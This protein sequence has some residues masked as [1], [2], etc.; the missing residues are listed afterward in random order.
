M[1]H[2]K[3]FLI[4]LASSLGALAADIDVSPG[5]LESLLGDGGKGQT[6]LKLKG[7]IDARDLAALENLSADVK[8]LDL[9][10]VSIEALSMPN[11]KYFGRTLFNQGEIPAY[12]FF[13][14]NVTSLDLPYGVSSICEGALA[15]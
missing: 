12:T 11:R 13:K 9:S 1:K 15:D 14:S 8:K 4:S 3:I 2:I 10:E 5:Q 6:E 7:K